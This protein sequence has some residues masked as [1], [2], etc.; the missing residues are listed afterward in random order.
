MSRKLVRDFAALL[1]DPQSPIK[2]HSQWCNKK[3]EKARKKETVVTV[4]C[5]KKDY[6]VLLLLSTTRII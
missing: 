4:N 6:L 3:K 5:N 2:S 1:G